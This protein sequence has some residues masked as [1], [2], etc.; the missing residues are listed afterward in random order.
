MI[1]A[2]LA[3]C[4]ALLLVA[5]AGC[6]RTRVASLGMPDSTFVATLN[7]LRRIETDTSLDVTMR[8]STR[9]LILRRHKVTSAQLESASRIL[10]QSPTRASDLWRQIE[11]VSRPMP[12]KSGI[13]TTPTA[14]PGNNHPVQH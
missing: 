3:G 2:R 7:E 6:S 9:R 13:T 14:A 4:F 8:D 1:R 12:P 10:A 11:S 5:V